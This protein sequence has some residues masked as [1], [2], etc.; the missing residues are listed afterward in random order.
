MQQSCPVPV[1]R[2]A[3]GAAERAE[4]SDGA[5]IK[6]TS[7]ERSAA[8]SCPRETYAVK[9]LGSCVENGLRRRSERKRATERLKIE[10]DRQANK[11][12]EEPCAESG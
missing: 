9:V 4:A 7:S 3:K 6:K 2:A 5:L 10:T 1:Q 8:R 12:G 11:R